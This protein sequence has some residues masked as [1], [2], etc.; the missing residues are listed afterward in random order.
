M[1]RVG[2]AIERFNRTASELEQNRERLV[3]LTQIAS[4]SCC[5][6]KMAHELKNS[7]TPIRLTV[8][9]I[10]ARQPSSDRPIMEECGAH[11]R[12]RNR[13]FGTEGSAFFLNSRA[14]PEVRLTTVDLNA[15]IQE[16][17]ALLRPLHASVQYTDR[18]RCRNPAARADA[19]RVK[20]I[21]TNVLE[22]AAEAAAREVKSS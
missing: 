11:R 22:N 9:E 4:C 12:Q 2:R 13:V 5:A 7:L 14:N 1:M 19:D 3:Y 10:L 16:R 18:P 15:V 20:G 6:E 17:V 21:L 8:E